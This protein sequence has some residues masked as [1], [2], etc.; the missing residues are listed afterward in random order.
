MLHP[1]QR[2]LLNIAPLLMLVLLLLPGCAIEHA[3]MVREAQDALSGAA[4]QE[5]RAQ[6]GHDE[7]DFGNALIDPSLGYGAAVGLINQAVRDAEGDL[8]SDELYGTALTVRALARWRLGDLAGAKTDAQTVTD[9]VNAEGEP[10]TVVWPRDRTICAALVP[11]MKIDA[12][13][14]QAKSIPRNTTKWLTDT[15]AVV[16]QLTSAAKTA[17]AGHPV[18]LYLIQAELELVH[19]V[20]VGIRNGP[21]G[22]RTT[23]IPTYDRLRAAALAR[24]TAQRD[25]LP[26][27]KQAPV[28]AMLKHYTTE[29][30]PF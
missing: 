18:R 19:V 16:K 5:N 22:D 20:R 6:L 11:L 8:K 1:R 9:I 10:S 24:L 12:L 13:G 15:E 28:T 29:L 14:K 27:A 4:A 25:A 23:G 26:E 7:S 17:P 2:S 21:A 30:A 3:R